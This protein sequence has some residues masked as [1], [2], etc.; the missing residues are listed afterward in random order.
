MATSASANPAICCLLMRSR[1]N[2][3][4]RITVTT[5][6]RA[7]AGATME[8]FPPEPSAWKKAMFPA[9]PKIPVTKAHAMPARRCGPVVPRRASRNKQEHQRQQPDGEVNLVGVRIHAGGSDLGDGSPRAPQQNRE[10][11]VGKPRRHARQRGARCN[12]GVDGRR[13][14][15]L[16]GMLRIRGRKA[17]AQ[18]LKRAAKL[19][20]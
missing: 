7:V 10:Q 14:G 12:S 6:K 18:T 1:R 8:T 4:A 2:V 16:G 20:L 3:T 5:G 17:S 11:R 19:L 13:H 9:P 15:W